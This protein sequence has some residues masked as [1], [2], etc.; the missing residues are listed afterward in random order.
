MRNTIIDP[1]DFDRILRAS[2]PDERALWI[3]SAETG[4][5]IGD[6]LRIRQWQVPPSARSY[7]RRRDT[8]VED[9]ELVLT[10]AKTGHRRS[11]KLTAR[12]VD[13]M[14]W[15]LNNCPERHP[16]KYLF[17]ARLRSGAV[18]QQGER[19][20]GHLHR[21]TAH[22]HF[23][24]AVKRAGLQG[25]G[26]TV[27]SLRKIYAKR[28]YAETGSLLAVQSDLGHSNISTT[29]LYVTDLKL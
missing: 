7:N 25:K 10:E 17:P 2:D 3:L 24:E 22:R 14:R 11:V 12:A 20:G 27:H 16:F 18:A 13:A 19:K 8:P 4:F 1:S 5:R 21:S 23:A 15:A 6:L 28:R 9:S 26:Y 29:L